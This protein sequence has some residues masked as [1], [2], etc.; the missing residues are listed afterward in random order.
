MG[1]VLTHQ[2]AHILT[3]Q[4]QSPDVERAVGVDQIL[5][6]PSKVIAQRQV[7]PM[8]PAADPYSER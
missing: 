7:M 2:Q 5:T 1:Q 6:H 3:Y 8:W 4:K